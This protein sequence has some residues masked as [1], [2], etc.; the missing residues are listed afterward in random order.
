LPNQKV[1]KEIRHAMT[2]SSLVIAK[3]K[4]LLSKVKTKPT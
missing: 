1:T 2:T 3:Q 4:G